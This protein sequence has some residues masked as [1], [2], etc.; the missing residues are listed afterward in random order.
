MSVV[1]DGNTGV[2]TIQDNTVTSA[3][4]V[5]GSVAYADLLATNW[6]SSIAGRG[7][8]KLPTGLVI[9]WGQESLSANG[10]TYSFPLTWPTAC[11][12]LVVMQVNAGGPAM[13]VNNITSG[14]IV[15]TT[16]F[17]IAANTAGTYN[18]IAIGN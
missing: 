10:Q 13:T 18:W 9:Q 16:Q 17:T 7:Y 11:R 3:K 6:T 5:D 8:Q 4:I 2:D 1:I 12:S 14:N 15:S